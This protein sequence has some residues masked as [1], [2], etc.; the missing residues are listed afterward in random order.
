MGG[1]TRS[2]GRPGFTTQR[3]GRPAC[4][5]FTPA[6][7][8]RILSCRMAITASSASSSIS[9]T[10]PQPPRKRPGPPE[11]RCRPYW[12]KRMGKTISINLGGFFFGGEEE[13]GAGPGGEGPPPLPPAH[14]VAHEEE[15]LPRPVAA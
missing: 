5:P 1:S 12:R 9:R 6:G 2:S 14:A 11:S 8:K 10:T 4:P 13:R 15:L 3:P 7:G